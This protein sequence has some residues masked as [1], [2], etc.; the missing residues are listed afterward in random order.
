MS[1]PTLVLTPDEMRLVMAHRNMNAEIQRTTLRM[2]E[3]CA[4]DPLM[5]RR[6]VPVFRLIAGGAA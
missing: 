5:A 6:K 1:A 2:A 3:H 4:A